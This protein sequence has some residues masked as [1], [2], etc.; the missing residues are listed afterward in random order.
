MLTSSSTVGLRLPT[1]G[2]VMQ[3]PPSSDEF[4]ASLQTP[5]HTHTC[6]NRGDDNADISRGIW[7]LTSSS[8]VG[9]RLPTYRF[10][11]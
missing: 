2:S 7:M 5:R 11:V 1:Y 9:A 10:V 4:R 3:R 6:F 8:T